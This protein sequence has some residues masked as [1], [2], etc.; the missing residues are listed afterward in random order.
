MSKNQ[1]KVYKITEGQVEPHSRHNGFFYAQLQC[2]LLKQKGI[3]CWIMYRDRIVDHD[4]KR[5]IQKNG[6]LNEI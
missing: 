6:V 2:D 5:K 1:Y 3:A 4:I